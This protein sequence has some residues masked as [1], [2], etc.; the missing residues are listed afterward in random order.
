M[1]SVAFTTQREKSWMYSTCKLFCSGS[2]RCA[3]ALRFN[4]FMALPRCS[5][6]SGANAL[7]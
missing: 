2:R 3:T 5:R 7:V 1:R 6:G 4:T